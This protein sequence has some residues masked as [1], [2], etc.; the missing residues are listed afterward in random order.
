LIAGFTEGLVGMQAGGMRTIVIPASLGYGSQG[1][2]A[3]AVEIPSDAVLV[4][5]L[6]LTVLVKAPG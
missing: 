5:A 6:D 2:Q 3:G 4:F 1:A